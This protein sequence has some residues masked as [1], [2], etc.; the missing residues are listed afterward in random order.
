L[1]PRLTQDKN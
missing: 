1:Q